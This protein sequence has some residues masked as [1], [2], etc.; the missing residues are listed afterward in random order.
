MDETT[1]N[2]KQVIPCKDENT[3]LRKFL[4]KWEQMDPTI[5]VGYNSDFFDIPYL[6]YRIKKRLNDEVLRLSPVK[7]IDENIYNPNSPIKIGLVNSLDYMLLL[8]KYIMKEEPSYKL[9][10]IGTKYAKLGKIEYN[11]GLDKLF[12]EDKEKYVDYNIRD[13]EIIEALE[14]K[15]KFIE[16]TILI[17]HL[18]QIGRASCRERV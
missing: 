15:Q 13:V 10:D 12:K 7:K 5:V 6:Y 2:G 17:S 16:L 18:C 3:L 11:G 9:G 14:E 8:K 4:N 1:I